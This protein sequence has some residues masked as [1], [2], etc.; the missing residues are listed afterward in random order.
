MRPDAVFFVTGAAHGIGAAFARLAVE[1]GAQVVLA[2]VDEDSARALAGALGG[3]A[4][5]VA[6]DVRDPAAWERALDEAWT[7]F[8]RVDVV[9]NNAGL[10]HG[11][12]LLEQS[13]EQLRHMV[14]VNLI[15]VAN[16][17]RAAVPRLARQGGGHVV[18]VASLAAYVPLKGQAFYS[19]TKHAVR[20]LHH[21]F[22]LEQAGGPVTFTLVCP[23]AVDTAMLRGQIGADSNAVA[24]AGRA[25]TAEEVG[26]GLWRAA[27]RRPREILLPAA[28]G[29]GAR[30]LGVL[31]ALLALVTPR[32]ERAG[33][34]A[35]R[36]RKAVDR[37]SAAAQRAAGER[38]P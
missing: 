22:A 18:D 6:L 20:A 2:D 9:V 13:P 31:P 36:R 24:F 37:R 5:A 8:G 26:E 14:D 1:R 34:A 33:L 38:S 12:T 4:H 16:G 30:L 10:I 11:G 32:V 23:G 29:F 25:L 21:A 19:A 27:E 15:G 3:R 35:L 17:L 28:G 7:R